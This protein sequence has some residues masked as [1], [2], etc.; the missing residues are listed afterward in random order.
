MV[1]AFYWRYSITREMYLSIFCIIEHSKYSKI[2]LRFK[3][4]APLGGRFSLQFDSRFRWPNLNDEMISEQGFCHALTSH[5]AIHA[6]GTVV[7]CCLDKEARINL[8]N[9]YETPF[10]KILASP[11]L[12][13]MKAGFATGDL[14]ESLCQ[15]C[16]FISRFEAKALRLKAR[17][18]P[19]NQAI[20]IL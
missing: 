9:I 3:K 11:R 10:A 5:I 8:G 19:I 2:N 1:H 13:A 18:N 17:P 14:C 12:Q 15:R 20:G 6:D 7:P 4:T 16:D